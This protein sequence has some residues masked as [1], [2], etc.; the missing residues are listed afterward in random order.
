MIIFIFQIMSKLESNLENIR[1][2]G[3]HTQVTLEEDGKEP[4]TIDHDSSLSGKVN[5]IRIRHI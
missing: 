2:I 3:T 5:Q 1:T 4:K